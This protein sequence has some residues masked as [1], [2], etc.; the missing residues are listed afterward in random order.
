MADGCHLGLQG[1]QIGKLDAALAV[2]L[3]LIRLRPNESVREHAEA[4]EA[5]DGDGGG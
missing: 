3:H 5:L 1:N 4:T 2:V